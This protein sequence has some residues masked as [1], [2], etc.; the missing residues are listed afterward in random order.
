M[1]NKKRIQGLALLF[2][3]YL[4]TASHTAVVAICGQEFVPGLGRETLTARLL[5]DWYAE[6]V[7]PYGVF[8]ASATGPT[9]PIAPFTDTFWAPDRLNN[10]YI[11]YLIETYPIVGIWTIRETG[12][13]YKTNPF[14][15][16]GH[17]IQSCDAVGTF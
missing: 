9:S 1:I 15:I 6:I 5:W 10:E 7:Y 17:G 14:E 16:H 11:V 3:L 12:F 13:L 8:S 4:P 2:S